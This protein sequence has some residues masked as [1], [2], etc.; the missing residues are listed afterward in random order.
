[1][2]KLIF[3]SLLL[4]LAACKVDQEEAVSHSESPK[5]GAGLTGG[6]HAGG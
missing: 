2:K 1:M 5:R 3:L 4:V 6:L